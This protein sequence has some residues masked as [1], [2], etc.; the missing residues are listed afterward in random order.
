MNIELGWTYKFTFLKD[1]I[2]FNGVYTV[3]KIYT[4]AE[5]IAEGINLYETLYSPAGK[6]ETEFE[7]DVVS[8]KQQRI[9]K[10]KNPDNPTEVLYVPEGILS[11]A[12]NFSVKKYA[13][14]VV[15]LNV[16][17]YPNKEELDYVK[18]LLHEQL[19]TILGF[20]NSPDVIAIQHQWY[21][22]DEYKQ[23]VEDREQAKQV[24]NYFS[25][26]LKLQKT[27]A[28]LRATIAAYEK[29]FEDWAKVKTN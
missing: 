6:T 23:L 24:V 15:A 11:E 20:A 12:P 9:Y 26:N 5:L 10:L 3:I 14:L 13:K 1:F 27:N 17:V 4:Y 16:G 8:Y 21:T 29:L 2:I 7:S 22:D 25:E 18:D 19:N 28:E